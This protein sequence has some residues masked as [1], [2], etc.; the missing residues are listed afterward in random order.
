[1]IESSD[2]DTLQK[3]FN[4]TMVDVYQREQST[5]DKLAEPFST[6]M[7]FLALVG[8]VRRLWPGYAASA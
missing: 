5:F 1:M 4:E 8:W 2:K 6:S 3:L 7:F